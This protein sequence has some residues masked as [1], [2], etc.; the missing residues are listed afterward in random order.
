MVPHP[1]DV[2]RSNNNNNIIRASEG[3]INLHKVESLESVDSAGALIPSSASTLD[4]GEELMK[5]Q[6]VGIS[7]SGA[8]NVETALTM[9]R[10]ESTASLSRKVKNLHDALLLDMQIADQETET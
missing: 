7:V 8:N 2:P 3:I 10:D 1:P 5:Q 4:E 6:A 9:K